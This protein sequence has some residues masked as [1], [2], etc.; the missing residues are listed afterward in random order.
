[1]SAYNAAELRDLSGR[2]ATVI[3]I[4]FDRRSLPAGRTLGAGARAP[5]DPASPTV[6]FVGRLVPHKRQDL[7]IRAFARFRRSRPGA[8]L[9]LVGTPLSADFA[10]ALGELA[11][12]LAPGGVTFLSV[13]L[14]G[15]LWRHYRAAT[16][17]LCLSEH[18]GFCI[19]LLESFHFGVPIIARAAGAVGEVIGDAGVLVDDGDGAAVIAELLGIVADDDE[20]RDELTA[21]GERR[22]D[23]DGYERTVAR[24]RVAI[25]AVTAA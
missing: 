23:G 9:V 3:P 7:V 13:L 8:R 19:P 11:Q 4:L 1:M 18:E 5:G 12:R 22:L 16:A 17:F 21:R 2:D 14:P 10:A 25:D 24:L 15:E 20:L 6:L